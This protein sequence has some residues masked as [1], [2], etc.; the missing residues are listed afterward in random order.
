[1]R[2]KILHFVNFLMLFCGLLW[3]IHSWRRLPDR[4]P[5][6]FDI[7]GQ[8]DRWAPKGWECWALYALPFFFCALF[9]G[10][11][12]FYR[13][14]GTFF[15]RHPNLLNIP[16][17]D[18]FLQLPMAQQ[19]PYYDVATEFLAAIST[20]MIIFSH[21]MIYSTS[22]TAWG[23]TRGLHWSFGLS[24]VLVLGVLV[25]Y[26]TRMNNTLRKILDMQSSK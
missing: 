22:L 21:S 12:A 17:K 16:D 11:S 7:L 2:I 14:N 1:M 6:H 18:V 4:I 24:L 20:A 3:N 9:Y 13:R 8:P 15:Q 19:K 25:G 26:L 5:V 23:T 10:I